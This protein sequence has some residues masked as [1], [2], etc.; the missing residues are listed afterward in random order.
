M[1]MSR[2]RRLL[3]SPYLVWLLL[4]LPGI[5]MC[6]G[7]FR[8]TIF[9]GE[10]MHSSGD[11]AAQLLVAALAITPVRWMF[12]RS[13]WP[14]WLVQRR[15]YIGVA[16]FA[17]ASLHAAVYAQRLGALD[18]IAAQARE[19]AMWT[20]WLGLGVML[21]LAL[22]SNDASVRFLRRA[23]KRLHRLAYPA[24]LLTLAHWFL[25]AFDPTAGLVYFALLA[26][27]EGFRVWRGYVFRK[28]RLA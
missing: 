24:A 23:W 18:T 27:L 5:N 2:I 26:C 12:P 3:N 11:L 15:R 8:G 10:L 4:A 20:G 28:Q 6:Q 21:P 1:Q 17:Y 22:T 19:A 14:I 9:Y 25:A 13:A 16:A 7:Y